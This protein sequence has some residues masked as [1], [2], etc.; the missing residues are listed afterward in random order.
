MDKVKSK[1]DVTLEAQKKE[2]ESPLCYIDG[3]VS[4]Q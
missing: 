1:K 4:S 2:K 3:H